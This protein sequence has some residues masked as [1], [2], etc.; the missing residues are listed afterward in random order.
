MDD[1][2]FSRRSIRRYT[3]EP[4]T[5]EHVELLLRAAT[6]APSAGNQQPWQ[7]V[8]LRDP[9]AFRAIAAWHPHAAMLPSASVAIVVCGTPAGCKWPQMW[10][11]DC[12]AATE[13]VL[14]EAA[15]L[16]LGAVWLGV[17]PLEDRVSALRELVGA[18]PEVVPFAVVSVGHPAEQKAPSGR[19][20]PARVHR[21]HW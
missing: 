9:E 10:E 19:F 12:S 20:D 21:D 1:P 8:V 13:N 17:H 3:D 18:P 14:V 6:A 15:A 5:D 2:V 4:V 7:F 16:G 11:Q